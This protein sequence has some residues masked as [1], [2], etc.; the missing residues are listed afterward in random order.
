MI[1]QQSSCD[2]SRNIATM[3]ANPNVAHST[4]SRVCH[5]LSPLMYLLG[6]HFLIPLFFGRIKITG[7][8]NLPKTG[9]VILAPTH[10]ARWD[11][12]LIPYVAGRC[13]TGRDLRFMV[14]ITECQGL[15]G[16]FVRRMGGFPVDPQRPSISTLRHGVELLRDGEALVIFP[17]GGIFRD[18]KVHSLK[19]GISRLALSAESSDK[20]GTACAKGDKLGTA[21]A[22]SERGLGVKI[23]P[24]T[25][26]YSQPYPT[27]G[28][29]A[30]VRIG[31]PIEVANYTKESVKQEAKRLTT[32]LT[33]ALQKL[34]HHEAELT[35]HAFAEI[36]NG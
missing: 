10:R 4:T 6:R 29:D 11:A 12:L 18:E 15:Q 30:T 27:W 8:E 20:P 23:V 34:N 22:K 32:D 31:C 13:V 16:W 19:P 17:E 1:E 33:K 2:S 3:P 14:T 28:T 9:P 25:I 7:Q 35:Q 26:Q 36:A 24:I 21:C 5:W